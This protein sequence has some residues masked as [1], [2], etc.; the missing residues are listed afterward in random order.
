MN[1]FLDEACRGSALRSRG[2]GRILRTGVRSGWLGELNS[3][4]NKLVAYSVLLKLALVVVASGVALA[5]E[6]RVE[7]EH[8]RLANYQVDTSETATFIKLSGPTGVATFNFDLPSGRYDID[9]RY[10]S[11]KAGQNTYA[12]YLNGVQIISWLGKDRD[13]QWHLMS[14]QKWHAPRNV[15]LK[16]GDEIRVEALSGTGSLAV[17]DYLAFS[18]SKRSDSM[19]RQNLVTIFPE[20]YDRAIRNPLKGF[21]S[22]LGREHEYGTLIKTYFKWNELEKSEC[23]GVDK[24]KKACDARWHGCEQKNIKLIPR[25]YLAWP[26]RESGWPADMKEGDFTSD[27]FK[28]RVIAL[29]KKLG[30]AWDNDSRVAFVEMGL[31]GQWGEMEWPDTSDEIKAAMA[32]QF[33][34]SFQNKLVMVR[35][36]NTYND[37][38]YNF[39]CFWD[40]WAHHD[41]RYYGF[42]LMNPSP[43]W[44]TAVIGGEVAYNWGNSYI[45]PGKSPDESLSK[46]VHRDYVL[47]E[48]RS[49]HGNHVGW[50]SSYD[51]GNE[52]VRAGAELVQRALGYRFVISEVTYP[53]RI[54]TDA[55]FTVSFKVKNTGSSPFYYNWPVEVS[56]LDANTKQPVWKGSYT[57]L[58]I[59]NWMPG[60]KW[61]AG[62]DTYAIPPEL[63]TASQSFV[64][65]GVSSGSYII[66]LAILDPAGGRPSAR[67]AI[68][69][70]YH[71]GRHPV[72]RVGVN[73]EVDSF[74]VSGFDDVQSDKSLS[75]DKVVN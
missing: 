9:A 39:G 16:K 14:E 25:V 71:G 13:D 7:A 26:R 31:I 54:D 37:D 66:A 35:W 60:D 3:Y 68:K 41:Q 36:P 48:I 67:F 38:I 53:K 61:D 58:D 19:L 20:E 49:L 12:L 29:I 59:R 50:I 62:N 70:Y 30:K 65:S 11:E 72:G 18:E 34:A 57:N 22:S 55:A 2:I 27:R 42:H 64:P 46:P 21:R 24:I 10:L 28:Q 15:A 73:Q 44:K 43:R 17:L 47:D 74:S 1:A 8:M 75:Y 33:A 40:S 4:L 69:N 52:S 23:D 45:Q 51:H 63:Y 56:L 5:G 6:K 32:A